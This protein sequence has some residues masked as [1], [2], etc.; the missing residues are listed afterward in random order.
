[1]NEEWSYADRGIYSLGRLVK[2]TC[3]VV[4]D[5]YGDPFEMA[6]KEQVIRNSLQQR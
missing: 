6:E 1:M 2:L 3:Y 4:A 5:R